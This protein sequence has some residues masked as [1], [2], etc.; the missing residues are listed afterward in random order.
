MKKRLQ[1]L[2]GCHILLGLVVIFSTACSVIKKEKPIEQVIG[3]AFENAIQQSLQMAIKYA[4]NDLVLPRTYIAGKDI[5]SGPGWWCSGFFPGT[6]WYLYE[7]S[8]NGQLKLLAQEYTSRIEQEKY[9][10]NNHDIGFMLNCSFGNGYRLTKDT[11][12]RETLITGARSLSKRYSPKTGLIRSWDFNKEKWQYP[13]IIDN[14]MNLEL[15]LVAYN[16]TGDKGLKEIAVSHAD[17]TMQY[18]Y[19]DDYSCYH[20][21]SYDTVKGLP[22]IKQTH[23]GFADESSWSRGQAWGLYGYAMMYEKTQETRFLQQAIN[24]ASYL[25]SHPKMPGDYIPYWDFNAANIPDEPRDASAAALMA[26]ALIQLSDYVDDRL[27]QKYLELAEKQIRVLASPEYLAAKGENGN[28]ILKHSVGS[29][30]HNSEIDVPL[31]YADYYF[32]EAMLRL[33]KK[34]DIVEQKKEN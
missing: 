1:R 32:V 20:V 29:K 18:H 15:L 27:S 11:L 6:L 19:R 17:K 34:L 30:P 7:Y 9:S 13:V 28:F 5:S 26:S 23:Q 4:D 31:T 22:H 2:S 25:I 8:N 3:A 10:T 14:M 33:K 24:I 16:E 12:C 21:V